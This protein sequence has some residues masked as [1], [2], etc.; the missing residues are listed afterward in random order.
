LI[1]LSTLW[2]A[3][4][5]VIVSASHIPAAVVLTID[6]SFL[7]FLSILLASP[8]IRSHNRN[9][10]LL[11]VL[12][13]L[14]ACNGAFH[15]ALMRHDVNTA[16]HI[17]YCAIDIVLIMITIIG[18]RIL[19]AFTMS[20]LRARGSAVTVR[21]WPVMTPLAI[22]AMAVVLIV[23]VI[24]PS[25]AAAG[26][27]AGFAALIQ[28]LRLLQWRSRQAVGVPILWILHV[29][30]AWLPVGLALKCAALLGGFALSAFWLH[31]LTVGVL[32]T[33]IMGVMSRAAL[34]H[35]GRSLEAEPLT[36]AA[37]VLLC[38]AAVTRVF[39]LSAGFSY[40]LIIVLSASFFTVAFACFLFVYF[41]ILWSPRVDGK[42]E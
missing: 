35:T 12:V 22:G 3:G 10:V 21:S 26:V 37:Y 18:G 24:W 31:A 23:D 15:V 29:S 40:P 36:V 41:P 30:Y 14:A 34:G 38:L 25:S 9:S 42:A 8:L 6:V 28:A 19:P 16:S 7:V 27:V 20:G 5:F 13:A 4:R 1:V 32:A 11:L 17:L 33:M 2:I 39:G